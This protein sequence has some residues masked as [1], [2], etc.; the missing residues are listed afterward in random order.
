MIN[1]QAQKIPTYVINLERR[2]D[3]KAHILNKF[4]GR[5]E[6][7]V[8]IIKAHEN[9]VGS[10]GLWYTI[11]Q[12]VEIAEQREQDFIL[13]CEDDHQFTD[14]YSAQLLFE[15]LTEAK[16]INADVILGGVSTV[17][18]AATVSKNLSWIENFNGTQFLIIYRHFFETLLKAAFYEYDIADDKIVRLTKKRFL[19]FPFISVQKEFGYSD[20]TDWNNEVGRVTRLFDGASKT[21]QTLKNVEKFYGNLRKNNG[22]IDEEKFSD[23]SIPTYAINL[24]ERTER[25]KHILQQFKGR[26]EFDLQIIDA[27]KHKVGAIGL[28]QSICKIVQLAIDNEDDVIII[29]EDDHQFT[30]CYNRDLL[31]RNIFEAHEQKAGILSG[32]IGGYTHASLLSEERLWV[33]FFLSAQFIVVYKKMFKKILKYKFQEYDVADIVLSYLTSNKMVLHPF[34][35]HQK[36]F[37]HSDVTPIHNEFPG[38]VQDMFQRTESGLTDLKE[39][40]NLLKS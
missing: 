31:L 17:Q 34:I 6:F 8:E 2:S 23:I 40:I 22:I 38:L 19:I 18:S 11:K 5:D 14:S 28:W 37:G 26:K 32:G 33:S 27:C 25:R 15:C 9:P 10:L 16:D 13:I 1:K 4:A 7:D 20:A 36:D 12:I 29:C 35:S 30:N 21:V 39:S 24:P 3:R